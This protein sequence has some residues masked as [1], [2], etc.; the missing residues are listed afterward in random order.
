V[1]NGYPYDTAII[2]P[3]S[4]DLQ[5]VAALTMMAKTEDLP[6]QLRPA[7]LAFEYPPRDA[8]DLPMAS[9]PH[10]R[11]VSGGGAWRDLRHDEYAVESPERLEL[12]AINTLWD[13]RT[14][15]L[16]S[17]RIEH[18]LNLVAEDFPDTRSTIA[19]FLQS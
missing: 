14:S 1:I 4:T 12:V 8:Q 18:W 6:R 15:V 2:T 19:A 16:F 3:S 5:S 11:G 13:K 7:E 17:T 9:V 10:P